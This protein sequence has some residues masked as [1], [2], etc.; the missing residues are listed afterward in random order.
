MSGGVWGVNQGVLCTGCSTPG[1]SVVCAG[2]CCAGGCL[3][4]FEYSKG[5]HELQVR[6]AGG[7]LLSEREEQKHEAVV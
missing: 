1:T 2:P 7:E 4:S 5:R 6:G 3:S